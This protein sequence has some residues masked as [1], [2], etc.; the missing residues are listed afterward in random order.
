MSTRSAVRPINFTSMLISV[1]EVCT[2]GCRHCG[3]IGT[4]R[5]REPR[6]VNLVDWIRD[7]CDYGIP[8]LI[9]TGGEPFQRFELLRPAVNAA[10]RHSTAPEIA[11]FT[12]SAW[13]ASP[14][15]VD[16]RLTKLVKIDH[17]YL[18]ADIFHQE[19]VPVQ[20]V[21]NVIEGALRFGVEHVSICATV[22]EAWHEGH[23]RKMF[24]EYK[25]VILF[26]FD[27]VIPTPFIDVETHG[28]SVDP[29][30]YNS[31][32]F[33]GTPLVNPNGD[34][35]ACHIGKAGAYSD[36]RSQVYFLGNLFDEPFS[37]I[38]TRASGNYEYQFLRAFGPRGLARMVSADPAALESMPIQEFTNG[39][40]LC[41][42]L[43][44]DSGVRE[45]FRNAVNTPEQRRLI[46]AA[47]ALRFG[48]SPT[49]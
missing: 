49:A 2:V 1:T 21:K 29:N 8:K 17:F 5:D 45:W 22:S 12:S 24:A 44:K 15:A 47:R 10:A 4:S 13:G 28:V 30:N 35:A 33:L 11:I 48:E 31:V 19:R 41:Y 3:F 32:C 16:E 25:D 6:A 14:Q 38:V 27:Q 39:C 18:S 36:L 9:F 42:K 37:A 26:N 23:I 43:L 20:Y 7:V 46:D 40:D 34:V